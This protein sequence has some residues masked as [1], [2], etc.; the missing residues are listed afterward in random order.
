MIEGPGNLEA[1]ESLGASA[2]VLGA[3]FVPRAG[4]VLRFCIPELI[5]C[6]QMESLPSLRQR[7]RRLLE[8]HPRLLEVIFDRTPLWRGLVHEVRR[9]CGKSGCRCARGELHVSTVLLDRSGDRRRNR[10]L[11]AAE[12]PRFRRMTEE[13]RRVRRHRTRAA[14]IYAEV[15]AIFDALEAARR[16]EG[17]SRHADR[18]P[19]SRG[20]GR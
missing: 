7:L 14:A 2:G 10:G 3:R 19:S 13:Y 6:I 15:L 8:E 5:Y 17:V 1:H 12:V 20:P 4:N 18:L 9:R 11:P 16:D